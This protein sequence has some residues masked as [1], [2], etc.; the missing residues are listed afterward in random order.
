[1]ETTSETT[2]I[3]ANFLD[4]HRGV[5]RRGRIGFHIGYGGWVCLERGI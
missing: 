3:M 1:M 2:T 4:P 5:L